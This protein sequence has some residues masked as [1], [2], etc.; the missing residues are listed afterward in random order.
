MLT[1]CG[2]CWGRGGGGG[3]FML[4]RC[5][6]CWG[7]GGLF[8]LTRCGW[9]PELL[10]LTLQ[11]RR[12]LFYLNGFYNCECVEQ[13][14]A[15]PMMATASDDCWFSTCFSLKITSYDLASNTE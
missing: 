14:L 2:G 10:W 11:E 5:G 7:G 15:H 8:M 9:F 6:G 12:M 4:T 13:T 3:L 1:C